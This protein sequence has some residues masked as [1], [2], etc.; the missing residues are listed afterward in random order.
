MLTRPTTNATGVT[1]PANGNGRT[2]LPPPKLYTVDDWVAFEETKDRKHEL[3]NGVFIEMAGATYEHNTIA[4]NLLVALAIAIPETCQAIGSDQKVHIENT[5]GLYPDIVVVCGK[6]E[7]GVASAL[8][9]PLLI[10]EVLSPSTAGD[11]RGEKFEKYRTRPTL[12]HYVLV[13]QHRASVEHFQRG[14]NGVW[15]LAAEHHVIDD[16]LT[17]TLAGATIAV[18]L[19]AIYRRVSFA[20]VDA[21]EGD[22]AG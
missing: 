15:F 4:A 22:E 11:D 5:N 10:V 20:P 13:E 18:P 17:V 8:Y 2:V 9:N 21:V 6:P 16:T 19:A 1:R 7:I 14:D 3:R 12:T